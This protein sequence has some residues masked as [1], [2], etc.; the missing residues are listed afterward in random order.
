MQP[1]F[2]SSS[3]PPP[4]LLLSH[5]QSLLFADT[6]SPQTYTVPVKQDT[7][8]RGKGEGVPFNSC[9]FMVSSQEVLSGIVTLIALLKIEEVYIYKQQTKFTTMI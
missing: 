7:T 1:P 3:P 4:L 8:G 2:P 5:R 9:Q 6:G